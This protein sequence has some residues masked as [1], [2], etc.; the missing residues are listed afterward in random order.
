MT[1]MKL[2]VVA[3]LVLGAVGAATACSSTVRNNVFEDD[4]GTD[5]STVDNGEGGPIL[6]D[7]DSSTTGNCPEGSET[8]ITGKVYDPA[9]K[10]PLYNIQVFVPSGDLPEIKTGLPAPK[11]DGFCPG[12]T[13]DSQVLNPLAAALTNTKGEFVLKGPRLFPG[14]DVPLVMQIGK[15][16]RKIVIPE[17]KGCQEN[18]LDAKDTRLPKN[19]REGDM[20]QIA[21]TTGGCDALECLLAG[22]GI[23]SDEFEAGYTG[24]SKHIHLFQ[25]TGGGDVVN[26]RPATAATE[27]WSNVSRMGQY[28]IAMLS[29]ECGENNQTKGDLQTMRNFANAGGRVFATHFHYT[30]MKNNSAWGTSILDF[31]SLGGGSNPYDVNTSFPKGQALADW[32]VEVGA[33][34]TPGKLDLPSGNVTNSQRG[35][36]GGSPAQQWIG[37]GTS[38]KYYSFNTPVGLPVADQCGRFVF[39]DVHS[40]GTGGGD[41]PGSCSALNKSQI[42]LE[43]MFFDLSSCVQDETKP[44]EPPK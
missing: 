1:Q 16:R 29:C 26:G 24:P 18:K 21:L 9:G 14:K 39:S 41:F 37:S 12:Q 33:S 40:A 32:L 7:P 20:P 13:C 28:D 8:R 22:I 19:G 15:W 6:L 17:V 42:A 3:A 43:Y 36:A 11:A 38:G 5:G 30:W 2:G 44:P 25:G 31:S 23:D 27:L 35:L 4:A 34:S 10:N